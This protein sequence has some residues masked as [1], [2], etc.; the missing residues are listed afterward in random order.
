MSNAD[1]RNRARWS[2]DQKAKASAAFA[3]A[4]PDPAQERAEK[5]AAFRQ[6]EAMMEAMPHMAPTLESVRAEI[7][8]LSA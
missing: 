1:R 8:R 6:M 2:R 5:L 7:A 4:Q 3:A